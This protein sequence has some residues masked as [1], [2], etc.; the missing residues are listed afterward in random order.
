[1]LINVIYDCQI[2]EFVQTLY[3]WSTECGVC[4]Q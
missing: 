1:M 4:T 3:N 2:A